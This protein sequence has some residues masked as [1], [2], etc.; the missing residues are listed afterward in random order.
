MTRSERLLILLHLLRQSRYPVSAE[1]LAAQLEISARTVYRDIETL[2]AQGAEI[3][4]GA[5]VGFVLQKAGFVLPPLMFDENEIEAV[6]LGM[7]WVVA[8]ADEALAESAKS[9]LGKIDAALPQS[10]SETLNRQA[11]YPASACKNSYS[12]QE[13]SILE[14]IR[15]ALRTNRRLSFDYTD[16]NRQTSRRTVW[17]LAVGYF[18]EARLMVAWCEL[19][20]D[21]RHFRPD[22]ITQ[23][24]VGNAYPL[25]RKILLDEWQRRECVDLQEFD[26]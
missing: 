2:R 7:R 14:T 1:Q 19:R 10:L 4:G 3:E 18:N 5:G 21:Y 24:R 16:A 6:V 11:L 17:P 25:P 15:F 8:N 23:A 13:H 9:A 22:R 12:E 26:F 20:Q